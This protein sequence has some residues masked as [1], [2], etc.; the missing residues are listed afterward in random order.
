MIWLWSYKSPPILSPQRPYHQ[1]Q[2]ITYGRF[3]LIRQTFSCFFWIIRVSKLATSKVFKYEFISTVL[4]THE[5]HHTHN[6]KST[7]DSHRVLG[8]KNEPIAQVSPHG[9]S[10]GQRRGFIFPTL[11]NKSYHKDIQT[12]KAKKLW[13]LYSY[14]SKLLS[15]VLLSWLIAGFGILSTSTSSQSYYFFL[16]DAAKVSFPCTNY[17][18]IL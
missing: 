18:S 10:A 6:L 2:A 5:D 3:E 8:M 9:W 4:L 14:T 1:P 16:P 7:T 13:I 17:R 12:F 11:Q 15:K